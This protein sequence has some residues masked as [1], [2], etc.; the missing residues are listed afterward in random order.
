MDV[1][2]N[3]TQNTTATAFA[4][5]SA[6]FTAFSG[7][8]AQTIYFQNPGAASSRFGHVE[9]R[10]KSAGGTAF[11][12]N[13]TITGNL[14]VP[15][16]A[17]DSVRLKGNS[18]YTMTTA[19]VAVANTGNTRTVFDNLLLAISQGGSGLGN[20]N[21]FDGVIFRNMPTGATQ[22]SVTWGAGVF[23][24]NNL[25]F[26]TVPTTGYYVAANGPFT[27]TLAGVLPA[28]N[29]GRITGTATLNWQP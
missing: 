25:E 6:H 20:I 26:Q 19:G 22:L 17:G 1:K 8:A 24:F 11:N 14:T 18:T 5:D 4:A 9:F 12:S 28:A 23:T 2:G 3:F 7:T 15:G 21:W 10:N 29:G 16:S 27:L 13:A